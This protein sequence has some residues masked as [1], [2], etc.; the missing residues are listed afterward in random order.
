[1]RR[2]SAQT[3]FLVVVVGLSIAALVWALLPDT[4]GFAES[5][6]VSPA[7][8][9]AKIPFDGVSAYRYLKQVTA[10]GPRYSGS[11]GMGKQQE[12]LVEHFKA[13]GATV[14]KQEFRARHPQT[15]KDVKMANLVIEWHPDRKDR[16]LLAA[17]YDTRPFP[18][19]DP[20]NPRGRFVGANDGASGVALLMEMGKQMP[21]LKSRWGVDFVLFDGEE[22]VYQQNDPYFLG[23]EHFSNDYRTNPPAHVYRYGILVDMIGDRRLQIPQEAHG[24]RWADTRPLVESVWSVAQKLGV[25]EFVP[26]PGPEVLDDHINL[27]DI[28]GIPT[29]DLIYFDYPYWHTEDDTPER[30]SA[31]SLA[32]V[33]WVIHQWLSELR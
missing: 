8:Q 31:D 12:M 10:I 11:V 25:R 20:R 17:H 30:C 7:S 24:L 26:R 33:G 18:D 32:K 5:P 21:Q 3:W 27:H 14:R 1:M 16:I 29:I 15:G 19:Q 6:T 23:S 4:N 2:I 22:L 9:R 13:Q 28:A